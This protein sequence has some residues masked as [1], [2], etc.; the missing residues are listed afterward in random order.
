MVLGLVKY[1]WYTHYKIPRKVD[2]RIVL[3]ERGRESSK[4]ITLLVPAFKETEVIEKTIESIAKLR[5]YPGKYRALLILDEKELKEKDRDS[6]IIVPTARDILDGRYT[7]QSFRQRLQFVRTDLKG[8]GEEDFQK[9]VDFYLHKAD[10]LSIAALSKFND[11]ELSGSVVPVAFSQLRNRTMRSEI[12]EGEGLSQSIVRAK[13]LIAKEQGSKAEREG[14]LTEIYERHPAFETTIDIVKR[15]KSR[16]HDAGRDII[17]YTVVPINYDGSYHHPQLLPKTVPSSKGRALNW[18]LNEI[19]RK[20]PQTDIIGIYD[21]DARPHEDVLAY[22]NQEMQRN[23]SKYVF[24]QGPI[25]LMRNFFGVHWVCKQSGLQ[26]TC[27]HRILYPIY[28]FKHQNDVI[29]FSG[30]NYFYT[31]DAIRK[32]DGYQPFHPTEDLGL[33][34]DVYAL[35]LE[36]KLPDLKIVPHPYE[37]L[38]QTTQTWKA[39]LKQQYRWASGGPYQLRKLVKN[40]ALPKRE[41]AVM[42]ARLMSPFP[43]CIYT[44]F[45]GITGLTLTGISLLGLAEYPYIPYGLV[46]FM[47]YTMMIGFAVFLATPVGI[48]LWSIQ[49]GY[50]KTN[51]VM[52]VAVNVLVIMVT[53]IPYFMIAAIPVMQAWTN[54]LTGWGAKTPRT[55]EREGLIEEEYL[56]ASKRI[57]YNPVGECFTLEGKQSGRASR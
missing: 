47:K 57:L 28:I 11:P 46:E 49:K 13:E 23:P 48:Y 3:D 16:Y 26:G 29:H 18:G 32:T 24:Y 36:G 9:W 17:D 31:I 53:T 1:A 55:D 14:Y 51:S 40:K 22:I 8:M 5:Y 20:L 7:D 12:V 41:K 35:R 30:T 54:P 56:R 37:E 33:A 38:E 4:N 43:M 10:I 19:E 25:Y 2:G 39:W 45:L 52:E 27:W 42:I 50:L 34:Y 15:L 44:L 6:R 21:S